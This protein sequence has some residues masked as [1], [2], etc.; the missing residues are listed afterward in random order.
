MSRASKAC[1][2]PLP[3]FVKLF[4]GA[5][6]PSL[7]SCSAGELKPAE[8]D[9]VLDVIAKPEDYKVTR[10]QCSRAAAVRALL[11]ACVTRLCNSIVARVFF[12]VCPPLAPSDPQILLEQTARLEGGQLPAGPS[13]HQRPCRRFEL[14]KAYGI[15]A[16][17]TLYL[18]AT[19]TVL[20]SKIR[21]DLDR[22]KKIRN[23]RGE[24]APAPPLT[25]R[26]SS[27]LQVFVTTG[28]C[29][30]VVSTRASPPTPC[31]RL[32][33][34]SVLFWVFASVLLRLQTF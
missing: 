28:T 8:I 30:C 18:Q 26:F 10:A 19:S 14:E 3:L 4:W 9:K 6:F 17:L 7:T 22:L 2:L 27:Q 29:V 31:S 16:P 24:R 25:P 23:H 32:P 5:S 34:H 13:P 20:D 11:R 33:L 12:C 15:S 21:D 1:P